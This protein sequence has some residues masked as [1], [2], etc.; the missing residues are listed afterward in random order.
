MKSHLKSPIIPVILLLLLTACSQQT[1][2]QADPISTLNKVDDYPLYTMLYAGDYS[3]Q[4]SALPKPNAG[5]PAFGCSLFAAL[6]NPDQRLFGRNFDWQFSPTLLLFTDPPDG[7]ASVSTVDLGYFFSAGDAMHLE[8]MA[9]GDLKPLL[10]TPRLPFDG[11]NEAGVVVAMAA[12]EGSIA[13]S[14]PALPTIGGI[15][16]IREILDHAGNV[17]EALALFDKYNLDFGS[18]PPMHYLIADRSGQAALVEYSK[19]E[20]VVFNNQQPWL[21][22]TNFIVAET[23]NKPAGHCPRYDK[24]TEGLQV[25]QGVIDPQ[26]AMLLLHNVAQGITQWSAVYDLN[27]ATVTI[28]I[29]RKFDKTYTFPVSGPK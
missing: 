26:Q 6:G 27:A 11:M 9:V 3:N 14:D 13:S 2:P 10:E 4:L 12:V 20:K 15:R 1:A 16:I 21:M 25:S 28:A 29:G 5:A 8:K 17:V 24:L 18:G 19:G 23:K 22:A 7:Y